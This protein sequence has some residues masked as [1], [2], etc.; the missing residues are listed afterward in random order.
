MPTDMP[1]LARYGNVYPIGSSVGTVNVAG[2]TWELWV[3]YNGSMKV[4]S[5]IAPS[6]LNS[7]SANVK[8]FFNY[9]QNSQGYPASSQHLIGKYL[10][11]LSW[12][13]C[14]RKVEGLD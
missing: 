6:P 7:F 13:W 14:V 2:R 10:L 1:R 12:T 11:G 3:G 4:F 8:D 5:F 9:L